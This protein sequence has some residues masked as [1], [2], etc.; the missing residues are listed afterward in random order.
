MSAVW[1][2]HAR[3]ARLR[4]QT[5]ALTARAGVTFA[6][7]AAAVA[8]ISVIA[9]HFIAAR[10]AAAQ[11]AGV[12]IAAAAAAA[13]TTGLQHVLALRRLV[14]VR[15]ATITAAAA[16]SLLAT[17]IAL[18]ALLAAFRAHRVVAIARVRRSVYVMLMRVHVCAVVLLM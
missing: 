4:V 8:A 3:L 10:R 7:T 2:R 15:V 12:A 1:R 9:E 5:R 16:T 6:R 14:D 13:A 11:R 18:T 17:I